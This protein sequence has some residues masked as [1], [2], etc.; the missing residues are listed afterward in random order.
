[1]K[2]IKER[3]QRSGN[4]NIPKRRD[5]GSSLIFELRMAAADLYQLCQCKTFRSG[6]GMCT[7]RV[8]RQIIGQLLISDHRT[9]P[10]AAPRLPAYLRQLNRWQDLRCKQIRR[11]IRCRPYWPSEGRHHQIIEYRNAESPTQH[12]RLKHHDTS[13]HCA[14]TSSNTQP[15]I[16]T[17]T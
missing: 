13:S 8:S 12:P 9:I 11:C 1:M 10:D 7:P 15:R 3:A 17:A 16:L 6:Q 2:K 5:T 14:S 4:R